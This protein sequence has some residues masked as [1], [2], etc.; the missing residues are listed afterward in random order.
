MSGKMTAEGPE[1]RLQL[2]SE[3]KISEL[4]RDNK[5]LQKKLSDNPKR[6]SHDIIRVVTKLMLEGKVGSAMKFL[7]ENAENTVLQPTPQVIEK[8]KALHPEPSTIFPETLIHGPLEEVSPAHFNSI[9]ELEIMR[10][11]KLTKG[12]G[13]PSQ[14][15]GKQWKRI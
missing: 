3:G 7:D 11:A 1:E 13:G 5:V 2:W 15:D 8:L 12:S 10:A 14:M 9:T 6:S 4:W